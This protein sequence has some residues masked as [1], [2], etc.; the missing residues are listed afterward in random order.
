MKKIS[1]LWVDDEID[2]LKPH[3]IFLEEK[4]YEVYTANNGENAIEEVKKQSFDLIF[5]DEIMPGLSGLETLSRIKT[6]K[7]EIPVVMITKNEEEDIMDEAIGSQIADYLIKPV[8]PR[9]I[10]L[11]IK[12]NIDVQRLVSEKTVSDYQGEFSRIGIEI[13]EASNIMDW[14]EI[15]KKLVCWEL[16]LEKSE[17]GE[18]EEILMMQKTEANNQFA[19]YVKTNYY[20]WFDNDFGDKP[21]TSSNIIKNKLLPL[22]RNDEKVFLLVIDNLRLDQW[23]LIYSM[24]RQ[25]F[26]QEE[27]TLFCSI[28]PTTTQYSRNAMF[29]GLMPHE[30]D[31]II[32]GL[33]LNDEEEGGKNLHEE[34]LLK[35]QLSRYGIDNKFYYTKIFNKSGEKKVLKAFPDLMANQLNVLVYNFVDMLSHAR[36]NVDMIKELANDESAYRSLTTSWFRHSHLFELFKKLSE[37]NVKVVVTTDHG[38]IRV[39]NPVKVMSE[40]ESTSN[41]RFKSGKNLNYNPKEVMEIK[42]LKK[43]HLPGRNIRYNYIFATQNDYFVYPNNYNYYVKYF[44]DTFQH[45]GV[46]ME[47]QIIPFSV[48]SPI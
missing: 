3:I 47:E 48:L 7:P 36:T 14:F 24:I 32:P 20:N 45:G 27:E 23:R 33:W 34:E 25:Y 13:G 29:A 1:I 46:S 22:L 18:M 9:Q 6:I 8:N 38:S 15:Y 19:R 30:I 26:T 12:K 31:N 41:L 37:Q 11:S 17:G 43:A 4:G 10:L 5:L 21:Y 39:N 42:D 28:L 35:K 44:K 40:R 2:I 16:E